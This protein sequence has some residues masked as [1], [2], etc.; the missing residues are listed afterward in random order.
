MICQI[1][2]ETC[3]FSELKSD[4]IRDRLVI[5]IQ[6]GQLSKRLQLE[7]DLTLQKAEKLVQQ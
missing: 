3:E 2:A 7:S 6:D 1:L 5:G 4:I